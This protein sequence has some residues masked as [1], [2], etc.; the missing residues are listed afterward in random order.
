MYRAMRPG[1]DSPIKPTEQVAFYDPGL[2]AGET[3]GITF[4]RIRNIFSS[5]V[6]TGIDQNVIDCYA[7]IISHY[8]RDD[9]IC[10][11]GFSRGAYTV[12]SLANVLNLCGVP[13]NNADGG[14]VPRYGPKLR[15]I[16]TDAVR[17]VYNHGAGWER[18]RNED[19]R[20]EKAKRFRE[21]YGSA[22]IGADGEG[23]GN[24]QPVFIGVFDTVAALYTNETCE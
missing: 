20:E 16:A 1:S 22:G 9:R 13:T 6:G 17:Y 23:Q 12:R 21:K 19:E 18:K 2:G 5:A 4:R 7:A 10:Q 3:R 15:K 11:F 14:P 8:E 24:V